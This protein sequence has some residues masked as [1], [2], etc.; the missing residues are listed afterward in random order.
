M[1]V[2][3]VELKERPL[4]EGQNLQGGLFT[5]PEGLILMI[6]LVVTLLSIIGLVLSSLWFPEK[7]HFIVAVT[8]TNILFGRA[9]GMSVGYAAG[10]GHS[11]VLPVNMLIETILVLL[12]YPL[13]VFS[14]RRLLVIKALRNIMK[15]T[16][17]AAET[18]RETIRKYGILGLFIF[19]WSPFWMTGP[20]VGCAIGFLLGLRPWFN[21]TV[22]LLGTYLAITCW[23]IFLREIIDYV[24]GYSPFAP[25]ILVAIVILIGVLGYVLHGVRG[26][27]MADQ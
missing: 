17:K 10:L 4:K 18:H 26:E 24:A 8:A 19:V 12:F 15:H 11:V 1:K 27:D 6:G 3:S 23:A 14:W 9:A 2:D 20:I 21:L 22:V 25:I 7:S 13:F 16:S 5:T